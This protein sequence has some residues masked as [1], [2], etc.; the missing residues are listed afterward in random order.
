M[1]RKKIDQ[2]ACVS[3]RKLVMDRRTNTLKKMNKVIKKNSV[4]NGKLN[5]I[6]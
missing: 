2:V 4:P 5:R 3:M 6:V 1:Q